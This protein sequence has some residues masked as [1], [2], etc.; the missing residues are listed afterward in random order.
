MIAQNPTFLCD[1]FL[2]QYVPKIKRILKHKTIQKSAHIILQADLQKSICTHQ[3]VSKVFHHLYRYIHALQKDVKNIITTEELPFKW[4]P[5]T[6]NLYNISSI[7]TLNKDI[8][9]IHP[10]L[11]K[12]LSLCPFPD[13]FAP[14]YHLPMFSNGIFHIN[15]RYQMMYHHIKIEHQSNFTMISAIV[16]PR[17][18]LHGTA[19]YIGTYET[20]MIFNHKNYRTPIYQQTLLQTANDIQYVNTDIL[21]WDEN[22][23]KMYELFH[24][25]NQDQWKTI[26]I[27]KHFFTC[28]FATNLMVQYQHINTKTIQQKTKQHMHIVANYDFQQTPKPV[29]KQITGSK[30]STKPKIQTSSERHITYK[31][32]TWQTR[33]HFRHYKNGKTVYIPPCVKTRQQEGTTLSMAHHGLYLPTQPIHV[34]FQL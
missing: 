23:K 19:Y 29:Q 27:S 17:T 11:T 28:C 14:Y 32:P 26:D 13:N 31:T 9:Q 3:S 30:H 7:V 2:P 16:S 33:G 24:Q 8:I 10:T 34:T 18:K 5:E 4:R 21:C 22:D 25:M 1:V 12:E 6:W 20:R 15:H